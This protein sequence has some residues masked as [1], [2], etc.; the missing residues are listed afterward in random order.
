MVGPAIG[1]LLTG[2]INTGVCGFNTGTG[3]RGATGGGVGDTTGT[4][5]GSTG[6][7]AGIRTPSMT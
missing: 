6:S 3:V 5:V 4:S 2:G 1:P 7:T